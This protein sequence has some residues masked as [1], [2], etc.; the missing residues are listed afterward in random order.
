MPVPKGK[1]H[2]RPRQRGRG[3][4]GEGTPPPPAATPV[5][6]RAQRRSVW[7]PWIG[8]IIG[9]FMLLA[10]VY[11]FFSNQNMSIELRVL[12]LAIYLAIAAVYLGRAIMNLRRGA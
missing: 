10:G 3:Q 6:P 11:F 5:K 12:I 7:P 2:K 8:W 4:T 1:K 9:P